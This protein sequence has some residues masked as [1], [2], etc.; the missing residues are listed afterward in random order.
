M[1][2][3]HFDFGHSARFDNRLLGSVGSTPH[4]NTGPAPIGGNWTS[5]IEFGARTNSKLRWATTDDQWQGARFVRS[6]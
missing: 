4:T 1:S 2:F 6:N 5:P 3:E